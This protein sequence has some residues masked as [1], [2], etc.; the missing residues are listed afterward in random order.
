M[1]NFI[2]NIIKEKKKQ[3]SG[4]M[5]EKYINLENEMCSLGLPEEKLEEVLK[6]AKKYIG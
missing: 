5:N 6:I 4:M 1:L 3:Y 2:E